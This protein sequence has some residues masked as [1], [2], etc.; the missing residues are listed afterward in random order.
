MLSNTNESKLFCLIAIIWEQK[1]MSSNA[2]DL[3]FGE[4]ITNTDNMV[5]WLFL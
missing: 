5:L 4:H 3:I 2:L 1:R